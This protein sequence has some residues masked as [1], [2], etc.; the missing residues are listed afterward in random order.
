MKN[1]LSIFIILVIS[2]I[3]IAGLYG[4]IHDQIT[5]TISNEYYTKFKFIQFELLDSADMKM[6][7][8]RI[9]VSIVGFMATWWMGL[10]IGLIL[11]LVGLIHPIQNYFKITMKAF[12]ITILTTL[13]FEIL[14]FGYGKIFLMN[15]NLNWY[16]PENLIDKNAFIVVGSIHNF[17]YLGG[18][19]GLIIGL[20]FSI[21]KSKTNLFSFFIRSKRV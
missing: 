7:N 21:S 8:P 11:S 1:K 6:K 20:I 16:F 10:F 12:G 4:I 9:G 5:Y 15:I 18:L 19:I 17:G 3:F 14:G 2:S 13:I